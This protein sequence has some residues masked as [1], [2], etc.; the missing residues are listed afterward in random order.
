[1]PAHLGENCEQEIR[2]DPGGFTI[3]FLGIINALPASASS[4][5]VQI[6]QDS[7]DPLT[8]AKAVT[9]SA[10]PQAAIRNLGPKEKVA[11]QQAVDQ[12]AT[13]TIDATRTGRLTPAQAAQAGASTSSAVAAASGGCW[14]NY[15]HAKETLIY[16]TIGT[17]WMQLNW[18]GNGTKVT[19]YNVNP[20]GCAGTNG[21]SCSELPA[22]FRNLSWEVR[23][24][25]RYPFSTFQGISATQCAQIR[26][27]ASG[28]TSSPVS[29]TL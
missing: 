23:A 3:G 11:F 6:S 12:Y 13:V 22:Q 9:S 20:Y 14:Y 26:G 27:G 2:V 7:P 8:V 29:C 18:C 4:S 19:S 17:V 24:L 15:Q 5:T 1:M 10:D 28:L 21:F 16:V 25:G